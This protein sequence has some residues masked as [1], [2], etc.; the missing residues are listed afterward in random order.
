MSHATDKALVNRLK[1]ANGHLARITSMIEENR[2]ALEIAQQL[3][4]V[5]AALNKART[6]LVSHHIEHHLEA[7]VGELSP[8]TRNVLVELSELARYL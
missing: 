2:S 7:A 8:E 6:T 1:R 3:Q 4:A 5:I